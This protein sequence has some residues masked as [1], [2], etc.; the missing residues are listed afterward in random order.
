MYERQK[1]IQDK[2]DE[3]Y[4]WRDWRG[5]NTDVF[6]ACFFFFFFRYSFP[7]RTNLSL[8]YNAFMQN[9]TVFICVDNIAVLFLDLVCDSVFIRFQDWLNWISASICCWVLKHNEDSFGCLRCLKLPVH[10]YIPSYHT[11]EL[12]YWNDCFV[13][14]AITVY[15]LH[16]VTITQAHKFWIWIALSFQ[17][18]LPRLHGGSNQCL[19]SGSAG[20][21]EV[22]LLRLCQKTK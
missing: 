17:N 3:T 8:Q 9:K 18:Y 15:S 1:C 5:T 13:Y 16:F 21:S 7:S 12:I 20:P 4:Q 14:P 6:Y 10:W 19:D 11:G 22:H 2:R